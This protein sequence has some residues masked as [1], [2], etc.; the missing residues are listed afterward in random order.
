MGLFIP[1][2]KS[3]DSGKAC[4]AIA[5]LKDGEQKKAIVREILRDDPRLQVRIAA[6]ASAANDPDFLKVLYEEF[7][8]DTIR[9]YVFNCLSDSAYKKEVLL[10]SEHPHYWM[11]MYLQ[12]EKTF[13]YDLLS[14]KIAIG[15]PDSRFWS[16]TVRII[17]ETWEASDKEKLMDIIQDTE[18]QEIIK[19]I[20]DTLE[21]H[22]EK[23]ALIALAGTGL[24]GPKNFY[25]GRKTVW[26]RDAF[27]KK[28][29]RE[30]LSADGYTDE[31]W[32]LPSRKE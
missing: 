17:H 6:I 32:S 31:A 29:A 24:I 14:G 11:I 28:C 10:Q 5:K 3:K 12:G 30:H 1:G 15:K 19:S 9:S 21:L 18:S 13:A 16:E 2:W 27:I 7:P 4:R 22:H 20:C 25:D 23:D 26:D 8:D